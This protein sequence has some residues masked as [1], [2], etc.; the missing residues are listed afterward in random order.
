[1]KYFTPMF[2]PVASGRRGGER[3]GR[4]ERGSKGRFGSL[5][6]GIGLFVYSVMFKYCSKLYFLS[7]VF[8]G[9]RGLVPNAFK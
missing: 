1:M 9:G 6:F 4:R 7:W 8:G 3:R 5:F 2:R